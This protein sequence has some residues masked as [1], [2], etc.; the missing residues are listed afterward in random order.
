MTGNYDFSSMGLLGT[1]T[2]PNIIDIPPTEVN[3]Q[4]VTGLLIVANVVLEGAG[5]RIGF[6]LN[7]ISVNDFNYNEAQ[8]LERVETRLQDFKI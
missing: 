4:D 8:L 6:R 5:Y 7:D 2:D 1:F 3:I